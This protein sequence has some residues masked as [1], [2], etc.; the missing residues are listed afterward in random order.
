MCLSYSTG[1]VDSLPQ[2]QTLTISP[3]STIIFVIGDMHFQLFCTVY[4]Q[5]YRNSNIVSSV[6]IEIK[7]K[8]SW[9]I[10]TMALGGVLASPMDAPKT[11]EISAVHP[12]FEDSNILALQ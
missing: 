4:L 7:M 5:Y 1:R 11:S 12:V 2:T 3:S 9:L 6:Y 8:S 10:F